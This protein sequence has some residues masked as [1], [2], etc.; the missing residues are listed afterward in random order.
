MN[1]QASPSDREEGA[2]DRALDDSAPNRYDRVVKMGGWMMQ[3]N[4]KDHAFLTEE[5]Y[6]LKRSGPVIAMTMEGLTFLDF[7]LR[8][9]H[10]K[11]ERQA[12]FPGAFDLGNR[13]NLPREQCTRAALIQETELGGQPC[14]Y[15]RLKTVA[16][17]IERMTGRSFEDYYECDRAKALK[18]AKLLH[19]Y[20]CQCPH[21]LSFLSNPDEGKDARLDLTNPYSDGPDPQLRLLLCDLRSR[22]TAEIPAGRL[23]AID[24][25][26]RASRPRL[27]KAL[28]TLTQKVKIEARTPEEAV[29]AFELIREDWLKPP[30]RAF[31]QKAQ[32]LDEQIH[33]H[34][35]VHD[36]RNYVKA[37]QKLRELKLYHREVPVLI[38]ELKALGAVSF[39]SLRPRRSTKVSEQALPLRRILTKAIGQECSDKVFRAVLSDAA[40]LIECYCNTAGML[41]P[42][43]V[44]AT[45]ATSAVVVADHIRRDPQEL[46]ISLP[47]SRSIKSKLRA[48]LSD[49]NEEYFRVFRYAID[50]IQYALHGQTAVYEAQWQLQ[51]RLTQRFVEIAQVHDTDFLEGAL[52]T[53]EKYALQ[54][55]SEAVRRA[56]KEH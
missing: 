13:S 50:W 24:R 35:W 1:M 2:P 34:F 23:A 33:I 4:V 45:L 43:E 7:L 27:D 49:V 55:S 15:D 40:R 39:E 16:E 28:Q 22:L 11:Q 53:L 52:T 44:D 6:L 21:I 5:L 46:L 17:R 25:G 41:V 47:G 18:V 10:S 51:L 54:A 29:A 30:P 48:R 14:S 26:Y 36:L 9:N 19:E 31:E 37:E 12:M 20:M 3:M 38:K 42:Q 8:A 32:P 56:R